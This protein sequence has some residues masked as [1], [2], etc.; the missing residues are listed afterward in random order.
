MLTISKKIEGKE[1][2]YLL[3]F[4]YNNFDRINSF[5]I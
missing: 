3:S 4:Y 2:C 5:D 1:S